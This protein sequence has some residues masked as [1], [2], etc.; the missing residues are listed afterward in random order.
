MDVRLH[1][2]EAQFGLMIH[3][4]LYSLLG[5][6]WKGQR[7]PYIAEWTQAYFRIPNKEYHE[8]VKVFNPIYFNAEEYARL[9][10]A[11]GMKYMVFTSKHHDGFAMFHSKATKFNVVDMTPFGRD[12]VGELAEACYKHG[13]K[14]GL[15]YSQDIDWSHPHGGGYRYPF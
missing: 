11:A 15:Y 7:M 8:L 9:A 2:K 13:I 6:E 14:L 3:F 10:K 12:V 1:F 5:G 4:G